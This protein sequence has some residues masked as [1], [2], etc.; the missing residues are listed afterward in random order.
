MLYFQGIFGDNCFTALL[1]MFLFFLRN[2]A[3]K[4][5]PTASLLNHSLINE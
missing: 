2:F 4:Q 1:G 3:S 5:I